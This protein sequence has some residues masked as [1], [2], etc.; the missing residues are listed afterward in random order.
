MSE[1]LKA[2]SL[3]FMIHSSL[4]FFVFL[5]GRGVEDIREKRILEIDLSIAQF[6]VQRTPEE[7][8][9]EQMA[10]VPKKTEEVLKPQA[11]QMTAREEKPQR[12]EEH[13]APIQQVSEPQAQRPS[14]P[15]GAKEGIPVASGQVEEKASHGQ[16]SSQDRMSVEGKTAIGKESSGKEV[17]AQESAGYVSLEE[18]YIRGNLGVITKIVQRHINYPMMARRMGWEG[19]VLVGFVLSTS[20]EVKDLRV[21]KSSGFDVLDREALEGVRK[22]HREFPKPSVDVFIKLPVVFKL[23]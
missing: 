23:D 11:Q 1:R 5:F 15:E 12:L 16:G 6:E 19:R 9:R 8:K 3:S 2:Y 22:S 20:G 18:A 4:L 14:I 13:Q 21:L 10:K 7:P 17:S